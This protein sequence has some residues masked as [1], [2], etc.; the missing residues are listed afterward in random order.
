MV[1]PG[2]V[3]ALGGGTDGGV[4]HSGPLSARERS[5]RRGRRPKAAERP[6]DM[7]AAQVVPCRR[8]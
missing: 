4:M 2:V 7:A 5:E 8:W 6:T 1:L 3:E